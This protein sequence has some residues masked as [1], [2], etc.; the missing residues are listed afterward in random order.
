[1]YTFSMHGEKNYPFRKSPSTLD[2]GL[3][4]GAGDV[5]YLELLREH[6][7]RVLE[8]ARP[9]LCFYL[10]GVDPVEG[11]RFGRLA[12]T[13]QGLHE[14]DRSVLRATKQRALPLAL[15]LSGG[16][17]A[18]AE[19]TADLHATVHREARQVYG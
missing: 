3:P 9:E 5:E 17:A 10:A 6:L 1:V 12:L 13:R 18:S 8:A 11:D 16:Y 15:V 4:D 14:R 19:L 7:P 2:L